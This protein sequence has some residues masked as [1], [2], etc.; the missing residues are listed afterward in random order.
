MLKRIA[1]VCSECTVK[2]KNNARYNT[3]YIVPDLIDFFWRWLKNDQKADWKKG[4]FR[5]VTS[6][7][8][9]INW[10]VVSNFWEF[11]K[12]HTDKLIS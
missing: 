9:T 6:V 4:I 5:F 3:D 7:A 8:L 11:P 1:T 2:H 12:H 10:F